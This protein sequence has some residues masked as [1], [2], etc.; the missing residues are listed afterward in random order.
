L[1][2]RGQSAL[3]GIVEASRQGRCEAEAQDGARHSTG[4]EPPTPAKA[5]PHPE[6]ASRFEE[7]VEQPFGDHE[8][9]AVVRDDAQLRFTD[10]CRSPAGRDKRH[11][12]HR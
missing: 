10:Q 7:A 1:N 9:K 3:L 6:A 2:V 11:D 8:G 4:R 12:K 5:K